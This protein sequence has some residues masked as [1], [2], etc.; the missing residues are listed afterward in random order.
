MYISCEVI[1]PQKI[2]MQLA[3][4]YGVGFLNFLTMKDN[5]TDHPLL[6]HS[7]VLILD[8]YSEIEKVVVPYMSLPMVDI[9]SYGSIIVLLKDAFFF[10]FFF[11]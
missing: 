1:N 4:S 11:V 5:N 8:N 10:L 2:I 7:L 6:L 3:Y 9:N